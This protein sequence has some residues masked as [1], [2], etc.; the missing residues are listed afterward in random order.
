MSVYLKEKM[1][2][3]KAANPSSNKAKVKARTKEELILS[4]HLSR[5]IYILNRRAKGNRLYKYL[6][7][8]EYYRLFER[9][10]NPTFYTICKVA[11]LLNTTPAALL[12]F[13]MSQKVIDDKESPLIYQFHHDYY[14]FNLVVYIFPHCRPC[15]Y[16]INREK[17]KFQKFS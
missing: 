2:E 12:D 10:N 8:K 7:A 4:Y 3:K 5:N 16:F 15:Q 6:T 14:K 1:K 13:D 11:K 17:Y 9:G